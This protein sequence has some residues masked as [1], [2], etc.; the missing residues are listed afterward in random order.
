MCILVRVML[1]LWEIVSR[2]DSILR[3]SNIEVLESERR[4]AL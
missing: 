2:Y 3:F 1:G 4:K